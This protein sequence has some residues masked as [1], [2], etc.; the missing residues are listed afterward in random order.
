M[1]WA[2]SEERRLRADDILGIGWLAASLVGLRERMIN[3]KIEIYNQTVQENST[4]G[5]QRTSERTKDSCC[6]PKGQMSN[7][8]PGRR[9]AIDWGICGET[10]TSVERHQSTKVNHRHDHDRS[11]GEMVLFRCL[12]IPSPPYMKGFVV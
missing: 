7:S 3:C 12:T 8:L 9:S 5:T 1:K 2:A 10:T 4:I 11:N 6:V